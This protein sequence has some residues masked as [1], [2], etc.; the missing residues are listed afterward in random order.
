MAGDT[1]STSTS[2][3]VYELRRV[4]SKATCANVKDVFRLCKHQNV[5]GRNSEKVDFYLN[6]GIHKQLISRRHSELLVY[7]GEDGQLV[8]VIKDESMNGT[9]VNDIKL[10]KSKMIRIKVFDTIT[11]GHVQGVSIKTGM[12]AEQPESEFRFVLEKV[13]ES[14]DSVHIT[15]FPNFSTSPL[16]YHCTKSSL[17]SEVQSC[18]ESKYTCKMLADCGSKRSPH[19]GTSESTSIDVSGRVNGDMKQDGLATTQKIIERDLKQNVPK[20]TD[21][22]VPCARSTNLKTNHSL[23]LEHPQESV[24][25]VCKLDNLNNEHCIEHHMNLKNQLRQDKKY[26]DTDTVGDGEIL[27]VAAMAIQRATAVMD[28]DS[29]PFTLDDDVSDLFH[30]QNSI[31]SSVCEPLSSKSEISADIDVTQDTADVTIT[32]P[33]ENQ[34]LKE[35]SKELPERSESPKSSPIIKEQEKRNH[36]VQPKEQVHVSTRL[37]SLRTLEN[38][39]EKATLNHSL[40]QMSLN[41]LNKRASVVLSKNMELK[42]PR[43]GMYRNF[44]STSTSEVY[45][46]EECASIDCIHPVDNT[47]SW[48]Q[49]DD[50]DSWY[51]VTCMGCDYKRVKEPSSFFHCGCT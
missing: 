42:K 34:S 4:G 10:P 51:H 47:I 27:D 26:T 19:T 13:N 29:E 22:K 31:R 15:D 38:L 33:V 20:H 49:C 40:T 28:A 23:K 11:F 41:K 46:P 45:V 24:P 9:F 3:Y 21:P 17:R 14:K 36:Q 12:F 5:F 48:V 39:Q 1:I 43:L 25:H 50:C 37:A 16:Y 35:I 7:K 30:Q 2:T 18:L 8:F 6:S 32:Y 44:S